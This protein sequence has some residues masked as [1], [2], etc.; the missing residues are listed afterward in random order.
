MGEKGVEL[1]QQL[2]SFVEEQIAQK[3][4]PGAAIGIL[5][6]DQTYTAG[7]G[8]TNVDHPIS[9]TDETLFQIGSISKT[10]T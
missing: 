8:V 7:L 10:F 4:V 2:S 9:V 5:C 1:F 6:Q 3:G